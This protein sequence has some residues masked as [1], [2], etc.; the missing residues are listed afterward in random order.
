MT[1]TIKTE[2]DLASRFVNGILAIKPLANFAKHQARKMM[3]KRAEEIGVLWTKEAEKLQA[4]DWSSDFAQVQ[5]P[6]L[7]YPDYY[8]TSFHAY[9]TGNLSWQAACE[10]ESAARAVHAKIWQK[11]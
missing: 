4:R 3:I 8:V 1:T 2:P 11:T 6:N 9:E 10:V 7:N 5:N